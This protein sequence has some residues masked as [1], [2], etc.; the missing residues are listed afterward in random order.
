MA[1]AKCDDLEQLLRKAEAMIN[2]G[3]LSEFFESEDNIPAAV[4]DPRNELSAALKQTLSVIDTFKNSTEPVPQSEFRKAAA[5]HSEMAGKALNAFLRELNTYVATSESEETGRHATLISGALSEIGKINETINLIA[6]NAS[7]E[8]ARAGAA[9]R[10]FSVIAS[11][12]QSLSHKSADVFRE[13]KR[14]LR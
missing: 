6:V 11:E 1:R 12:I 2:V 10:G 5:S 9:G 13:L 8:A 4:A 7:V 14:Q 3:L